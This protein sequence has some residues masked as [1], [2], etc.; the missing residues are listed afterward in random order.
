MPVNDETLRRT[1]A[2]LLS[3]RVVSRD[4][5]VDE[6]V[7]RKVDLGHDDRRLARLLQMDTT[8]AEVGD[9][10]FHVPSLLEGTS[11]TVRV[12]GDDAREGFVRMHPYLSPLGWWLISDEVELLDQSG[13]QL[14]TLGTDGLWLEGRDTDVV[15]GPEGWLRDL[16]G[17]WATV[18]VVDGALRWSACAAPPEPTEA[19][20]AA[21][22][23]G[24]EHALRTEAREA[25]DRPAP[26]GLR[27][28]FGDGPIHEALVADR[29]AFVEAPIPPL[30]KLYEAAGLVQQDST[31]AEAGFDWAALRAWQNRNRLAISYGL[32]GE[33]IDSLV[34]LIAAFEKSLGGEPLAPSEPVGEPKAAGLPLAAIL[35]DGAVAEAFWDE[36]GRRDRS[37]AEASAASPKSWRPRSTRPCP[38]AWHGCGLVAST[39]RE[40]P[41]RPSNSWNVPSRPTAT[42]CPRWWTWRASQPTGVTH[43]LPID[44][45]SRPA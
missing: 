37:V 19:Q 4:A 11:W 20:V 21:V 43:P 32:D 45:C 35:D 12:D 34:R 9:G 28:A 13:E 22:R 15:L 6:L 8:F 40:R 41:R 36:S 25:I 18:D 5:L 33:Q 10:V 24:F 1:V 7:A 16:A 27:F 26:A 17:R 44:S 30:S 14:G 2:E 29:A 23:I 38:S 42:T 31:I 39:F 3:T